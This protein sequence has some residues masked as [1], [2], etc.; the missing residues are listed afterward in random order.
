MLDN[1]GSNPNFG[2]L[3]LSN[4]FIR[5]RRITLA[6]LNRYKLL[7]IKSV[8]KSEGLY[9]R[10]NSSCWYNINFTFSTNEKMFYLAS[11]CRIA[12]FKLYYDF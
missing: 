4:D 8:K 9:F 3:N 10:M 1:N 2:T 12:Y 7:T 5:N 11:F 6:Q